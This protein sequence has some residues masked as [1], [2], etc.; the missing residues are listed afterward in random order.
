MLVIF[1][2]L[3]RQWGRC[4]ASCDVGGL[5]AVRHIIQ[6]LFCALLFGSGA[7]AQT[8]PMKGTQFDVDLYGNLYLLDA[9]HNTL[10]LYDKTGVLEREVGGPG[11]LDGQFDRPGGVWAHNGI[12]VYVADYGNHRIE[13][14]DRSLNFVSSFSTRESDNPDERFG[15]PTDMAL[16]RLGELF[17]C[18]SENRRIV[19]VDRFNKVERTFGGFGA[20]LGRLNAP[21]MVEVGPGDRVYVL[22]GARIAVFDAFGN[23]MRDLSGGVFSRPAALYANNDVI[24]VLDGWTLYLFDADERATGVLALPTIAP[25]I[26]D[27]LAVA[28]AGGRVYLLSSSGLVSLA[29]PFAGGN[30]R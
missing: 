24:A 27:C 12:D 18:D 5:D 26:I 16:S 22:D 28:I 8:L 25:S 11:W 20:G 3:Q 13:R 21:T 30:G 9:E 2:L 1:L 19:K 6:L 7:G 29:D 4:L 15:Y 17:I 23:F 10:R 14:F